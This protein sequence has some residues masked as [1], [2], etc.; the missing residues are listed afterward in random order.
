M[1]GG[2]LSQEFPTSAGLAAGWPHALNL[3][4]PPTCL[5]QAELCARPAP[6][7]RGGACLRE[8]LRTP[9]DEQ[10]LAKHQRL[11][12]TSLHPEGPPEQA[13]KV[14]EVLRRHLVEVAAVRRPGEP[15]RERDLFV[16]Y[17]PEQA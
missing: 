6:R 17:H 14:V 3:S 10:T 4:A 13:L 1:D 5:G 8:G 7:Q 15:L 12:A 11:Q 2:Q 9:W 16:L